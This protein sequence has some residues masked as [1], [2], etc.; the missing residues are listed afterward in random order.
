MTAVEPEIARGARRQAR[1]RAHA[2]VCLERRHGLD[3]GV[4]DHDH[5]GLEPLLAH[6]R[7]RLVEEP[8][9]GVPH[10]NDH[11]DR[12]PSSEQ[13][14]V[15]PVEV[16]DQA[17]DAERREHVL[18]AA[19]RH[20][21]RPL[22]IVEQRADRAASSAGSSASTPVSP[23]STTERTPPT[24]VLTTGVPRRLRLDQAHR[25]PLVV[26]GQHDDVAREAHVGH[27]APEARPH[28]PVAE[29]ARRRRCLSSCAQLAVADDDEARA[30]PVGSSAAVSRKRS[31][32]LIGTSRAT[33]V[34]TSSPP[35]TP[36]SRAH[37]ARGA[38]ARSASSVKAERS[39]PRRTTSNFSGGRDAEADEVVADLLGHR[40]QH[41]GPAREE[42]L[43]ARV[44]PRGA[45]RE[46]TGQRVAVERVDHRPGAAAGTRASPRRGRACRPS[47]HAC[48][49]G[50]GDRAAVIRTSS[51]SARASPGPGSR[52]I[53][54]M[55]VGRTPMRCARSSIVPSSALSLPRTSRVA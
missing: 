42:A 17:L 43:D 20:G 16:V 22:A 11:R 47:P 28:E 44:E 8:D 41:V 25:R 39:S 51:A 2:H 24:F 49:R 35:P 29:R 13:P 45:R 21:R 4:V 32:R 7:D 46:V 27:V 12:P 5:L 52:R 26:G 14:P 33:S 34:T 54:A 9:V 53:D 50:P 1:L 30:G 48:A 31:T 37:A 36:H 23:S 6:A 40:D 15:E 3:R 55:S 19:R 18:A 38:P 10:R